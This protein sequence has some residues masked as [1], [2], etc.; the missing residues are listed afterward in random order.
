MLDGEDLY[1]AGVRGVGHHDQR[2]GL[3]AV[4]SDGSPGGDPQVV[5]ELT[6]KCEK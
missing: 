2:P 4:E 3:V 5:T 1:P 6:T